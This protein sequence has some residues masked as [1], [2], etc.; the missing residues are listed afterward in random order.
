MRVKLL[1]YVADFI[2]RWTQYRATM[3]PLLGRK[4]NL[5]LVSSVKALQCCISIQSDGQTCCR[6]TVVLHNTQC[7]ITRKHCNTYNMNIWA[8]ADL[9]R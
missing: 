1:S 4:R 2:T 9:S 5:Q 6:W 3:Q 7:N 8:G